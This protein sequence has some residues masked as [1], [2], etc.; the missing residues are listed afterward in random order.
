MSRF[1]RVCARLF[2]VTLSIGLGSGW[3]ESTPGTPDVSAT[4]GV[5]AR[6]IKLSDGLDFWFAI[7]NKT[8]TTLSTVNL[9]RG[10][11]GASDATDAVH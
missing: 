3:A 2:V 7:Q 5:S 11:Q 9:V 1:T 10:P 4:G 8:A 6:E